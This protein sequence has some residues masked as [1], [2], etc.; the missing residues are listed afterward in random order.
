MRY[1]SEGLG[2]STRPHRRREFASALPGEV[3]VHLLLY[4]LAMLFAR[5]DE[6]VAVFHEVPRWV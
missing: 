5:H 4:H 6:G 1:F 3:L 2:A